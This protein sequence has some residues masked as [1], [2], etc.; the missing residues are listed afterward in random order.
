VTVADWFTP[1]GTF[2]TM[3]GSAGTLLMPVML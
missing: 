2:T 3:L 1:P